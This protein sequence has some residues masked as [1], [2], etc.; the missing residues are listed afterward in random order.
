MVYLER[1]ILVPYRMGTF[2]IIYQWA[3]LSHMRIKDITKRCESIKDFNAIF[4]GVGLKQQYFSTP[5]LKIP[6]KTYVEL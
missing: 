6:K 2:Q 3:A 4:R 5:N 1:T